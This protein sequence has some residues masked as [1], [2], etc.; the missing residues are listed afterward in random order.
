MKTF[1]RALSAAS[2]AAMVAASPALAAELT[3]ASRA[4]L[5]EL[6]LEQEVLDGIDEELAV[7]PEWITAAEGEG[8]VRIWTTMDDFSHVQ[9]VFNA[10]YPNIEVEH[11]QVSGTTQRTLRPLVAFQEGRSVVDI[12]SGLSG[13]SFMFRDANAFV[14]L[15][16][17]PAY[18]RA[19]S[20]VFRVE[21]DITA[22]ARIRYWCMSYN[23]DVIAP[24]DLPAR[25]EDLIA[26][27]EVFGD[28]N[29]GLADRANQWL[30]SLWEANGEEWGRQFMQDLF[31]VLKPQ[32]R[33][34]GLNAMLSLVAVGEIDAAIPSAMER[35][36]QIRDQGA[37]VGHHCPEP[38]PVVVSEIGLMSDSPNMNASQVMT[39]WLLS[40]EG[41]IALFWADGTQPSHP[42]LQR[43]EFVA[44]PELVEGKEFIIAAE[45]DGDE[46][47]ELLQL[48]S[49][50]W[51]GN[52]GTREEQ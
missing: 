11:S 21:G 29:L 1:A 24:E 46:E 12:L 41:Q 19:V 27:T 36:R 49:E 37:P 51:L 40:K 44:F 25:W 30:P 38:V 33:K 26:N 52:G 35:V 17:L 2:V 39:N 8:P 15:S 43:P 13:N 5:E 42:D 18:D 32:L 14:D 9:E 4:M 28:G 10:R 7:P 22:V 50:L 31:G 16:A 20:E 34:E 48:W 6:G 23:T 3:D 45:R 47:S